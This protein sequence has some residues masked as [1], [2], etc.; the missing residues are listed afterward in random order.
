MDANFVF[1]SLSYLQPV[2]GRMQIVSEHPS[3]ALIIIDY[4]HS[5]DALFSVLNSLRENVKGRIITL[6]GCG[7]NRDKAK[8]KIMGKIAS[9]HSDEVIVTDDNPRTE[10]PSIIR[11]EIL[12]GCPNAI[13]IADRNNAI[14]YAISKL[15]KDDLLLIAGKGHE[16]FQTIGTESLPF[17][18]FTVAKEAIKN[19]NKNELRN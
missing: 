6:F 15:K 1:K 10:Q 8:R 19:L 4:A 7:G 3:E 16:S 9:E 14:K 13:E 18:D 2:S 5:P 17:D 12:I 11:K